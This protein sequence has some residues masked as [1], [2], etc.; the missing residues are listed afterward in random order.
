MPRSPRTPLARYALVVEH[1]RGSPRHV[2]QKGQLPI[3]PAIAR[4][5]YVVVDL[6]EAAVIESRTPSRRRVPVLD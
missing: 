3:W 6:S 4:G 2:F 5:R 1:L